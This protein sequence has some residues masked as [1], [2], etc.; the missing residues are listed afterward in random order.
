MC[1]GRSTGTA[2]KRPTH[3]SRR[4]AESNTYRFFVHPDAIR[5]RD[6]RIEEDALVHQISNVLR[7]GAGSQVTLLDNSGWEHGVVL[8]AVERQVIT[9]SVEARQL[10]PGE[11]RLKLALYVALLKGERFEWILQK[12]TELGAT[13]FV[14]LICE[15]SI[16][17]DAA[18]I[19]ATKIERWERIVREAAEQ[20]RRAKLPELHPAQLFANAC[21]MA[22]PRARTMLLWDGGGTGLRATLRQA[23]YAADDPLSLA[24]LSGPEGGWTEGEVNA[25]MMYDIDLVSIGRRTLRAE[26]APLVAATAIF[27]EF[28]EL[29]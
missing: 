25:A 28:G 24:I 8:D 6:V 14:P 26:T 5:G 7:L 29:D 15:R 17:D 4:S 18:D 27:Y 11:P 3:R 23:T 20:S 19:G 1:T 9:G 10:A 16:V 12:G 21:D 13:V 22:R 2:A